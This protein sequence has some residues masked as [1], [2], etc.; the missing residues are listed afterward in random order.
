MKNSALPILLCIVFSYTSNAQKFTLLP[1]FG[2]EASKTFLSYNNMA[3]FIPKDKQ[4]APR[5]GV[6]LD[7]SFKKSGGPYVGIATSR[8]TVA[9]NL[10]DP[11]S[12]MNITSVST[13]KM[14]LRLEGGYQIS[15][16]PLYFRKT[17]TSSA[18]SAVV[19]Q[20]K[21]YSQS[22]CGGYCSRY[23]SLTNTSSS[24][25]Q[26]TVDKGW[27]VSIQPSAGMAFIPAVKTDVRTQVQGNK[28]SVTYMAGN[29]NSAVTAGVGFEFGNSTLDKRFI[30]GIQY[31]KGIG[32]L[33]SRTVSTSS[34]GK[35]TITTLNSS[36]SGLNVSVGIPI[37][38]VKKK[39]VV[40]QIV[41][42]KKIILE[43]KKPL[44]EKKPN[45]ERSR[46]SRYYSFYQ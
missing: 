6:R 5:L 39:P 12:G 27:Y 21:T 44:G 22:R 19:S 13:G 37:S 32:N 34:G 17:S 4:L 28:T 43:E 33:D 10:D 31:L 40:K 36:V 16:K 9:V 1:Q 23:R 14:Q 25:K 30:I 18:K 46:C 3:S 20:P 24:A 29:Y 2:H 42:E 26:A 41:E 35:S 15:T 8:S 11:A 38:L 45:K 7:Y